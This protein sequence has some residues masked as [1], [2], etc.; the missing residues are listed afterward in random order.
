M[1][2]IRMEF[3]GASG[4]VIIGENG[5][6]SPTF[7][8]NGLS[9]NKEAIV[10]ASIFV[11]GT[12]TTFNPRYKNE[13]E[14]WFTRNGVRP[15]AV[16]KC[17]FE[18]KQCPPDFITTYLLWVII[19]GVIL[20]ICI[21]GCIAGFIVAVLNKRAETARLNELWQI[22][23]T[24]LEVVANK[25]KTTSHRSLQ[26]SVASNKF[27]VDGKCESRNYAYFLYQNEPI[28]ALKHEIRINLDAKDGAAF[29]MMRQIENENVNRFVGICMDGPQ[30]LSVWR[31]CSR[32][33]INDVIMKGAI[34]MDN[35]FV[36]SLLKDIANGISFIHHSFLECHGYITAKCC[37]VSDRWQVKVSDYGID[38]LRIADKRTHRDLLWTAPEILRSSNSGKS[39][40]A[41]IYSFGIICAQVVTQSP[42]WDLDNRKEDPEELIYMIKKGGHNAPRPPLDVQENGDV[43]QALVRLKIFTMIWLIL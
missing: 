13:K 24:S 2:N 29:R 32:G 22:P 12:N 11:N 14:I 4:T 36:V 1:E 42:P 27:S 3:E 7:Y 20:L 30:M 10:M 39:K 28:A 6:R 25:E 34:I 9:E 33:S 18:G 15:P 5:T 40:E 37:V 17:G 8:I 35:F 26:S 23:F 16:P 38:K 31:Y 19:A 43:N 21:L 41:D